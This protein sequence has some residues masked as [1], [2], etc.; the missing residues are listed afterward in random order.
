[1]YDLIVVSRSDREKYQKLTQQTI[2][3]CLTTKEGLAVSV[4]V[5]ETSGKIFPY[6]RVNHNILYEGEFNYNR[7]L[8]LGLSRASSSIHMLANNDLIFRKG[9]AKTGLIMYREKILSASLPGQL[10]QSGYEPNMIFEG[11][12]VSHE[13]SGWLIFVR[14]EL[15]KMMG[16]LPESSTFWYSDNNYADRL[17]EL[18]VKHYL[19]THARVDHIE[20]QTFNELDEETYW[21]YRQ[22]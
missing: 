11:Y 5:V 16:K 20:S 6:K 13:L 4:I 22:R 21:K 17:R 19:L 8:N 3:S 18:S 10:T 1:M 9:W 14:Y 12:E 15:M 2:D 7:C